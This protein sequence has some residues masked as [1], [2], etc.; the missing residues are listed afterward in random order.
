MTS[1]PHYS[2]EPPRSPCHLDNNNYVH[3]TNSR[4]GTAECRHPFRSPPV[5]I[6]PPVVQ[7]RP[8]LTFACVHPR[9][10]H[11]WASMQTTAQTRDM[12]SI[13]LGRSLPRILLHSICVFAYK[14]VYLLSAAYY[15]ATPMVSDNNPDNGYGTMRALLS[16]FS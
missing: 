9:Q 1:N 10:K 12:V 2:R 5:R 15:A 3:N 16:V 11:Q 8:K 14:L 6:G 13:P 7:L 4:Y